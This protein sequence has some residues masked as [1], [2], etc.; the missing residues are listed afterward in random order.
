MQNIRKNYPLN[1]EKNG[2]TQVD[3][4]ILGDHEILFSLLS[5]GV[6]ICNFQ[7]GDMIMLSS[8]IAS[9]QNI[10]N[11]DVKVSK[12][13]KQYLAFHVVSKWVPQKGE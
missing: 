11:R 13:R 9:S 2:F 8:S 7:S 1:F 5:L 3:S 10:K 6:T 4:I 12:G